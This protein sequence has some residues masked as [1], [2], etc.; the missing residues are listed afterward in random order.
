MEVYLA[1]CQ[2]RIPGAKLRRTS[3]VATQGN[4]LRIRGSP[5]PGV[6]FFVNR[7]KIRRADVGVNLR[8]DQALV[9]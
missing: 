7:A 5:S 4:Q 8:G 9:P 1:M 3:D 6:G 2:A